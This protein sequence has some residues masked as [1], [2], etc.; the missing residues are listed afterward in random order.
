M[1]GRRTIQFQAIARSSPLSELAFSGG[2][3][4]CVLLQEVERGRFFSGEFGGFGNLLDRRGSRHLRQKL[5]AAVMLEA[6][7][8]RDEPAHN[9]V[10]LKAAE[11]VDL[12]RHCCFRK[13]AGGLLEAG[14]GD[15]GVGRGRRLGETKEERTARGG[16]APIGGDTVRFPPEAE[17]VALR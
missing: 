11:V 1:T 6:R 12:A 2:V 13:N 3:G 10:F 7:T 16:P 5:D 4:L 8:S 15:K 9:D 14:S 17:F